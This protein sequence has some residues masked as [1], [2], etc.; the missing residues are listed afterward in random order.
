MRRIVHP[1]GL[2]PLSVTCGQITE[3]FRDLDPDFVLKP[4]MVYQQIILHEALTR[5]FLRTKI[6]TCVRGDTCHLL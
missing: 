4:K 2:R 1:M 3:V 5:A 6:A